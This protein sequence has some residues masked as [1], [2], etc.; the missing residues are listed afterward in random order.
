MRPLRIIEVNQEKSTATCTRPSSRIEAALS[1]KARGW[2]V[3]LIPTK[4]KAPITDDWANLDYT[5]ED[6]QQHFQY[7]G[8]IGIV[9]GDASGSLN[10]CDLDCVEALQLARVLL[11]ETF[12]FGRNETPKSHWIYRTNPSADHLELKH[13]VTQEK[14]LELRGNGGHQTVFPP[15]IHVSG[16]EIK[17]CNDRE[18]LTVD[19]VELVQTV[20]TLAAACL[21]LRHYPA[22]G[23]RDD[24]CCAIH[25]VLAR[26]DWEPDKA[27]ELVDAIATFAGDEEVGKRRKAKAARKNIDEGK[28]VMGWPKLKE[29]LGSAITAQISEWLK[30]KERKKSTQAAQLVDLAL[31]SATKFFLSQD[32]FSFARVPANDH[33]ENIAVK[34]EAFRQWLQ[35]TIYSTTGKPVGKNAI[36]EAVQIIDAK[37]RFENPHVEEVYVRTALVGDKVYLDLANDKWEVLEISADGYRVVTECPVQFRRLSGMKALPYPVAGGSLELLRKYLNVRGEDDWRLI[38]AYL[39]STLNKGPFWMLVIQGEPGSAKTTLS[40]IVKSITDPHELLVRS[41]PHSVEDVIIGARNSWILSYDNMSRIEPWLSDI[42][43]QVSTGA[44][45]GKREKYTDLDEILVRVQRPTIFNGVG[46]ILRSDFSNRALSVGLRKIAKPMSQKKLWREFESDHPLILGALLNVVASILKRLPEVETQELVLTRMA[47]AAEWV[48][49]AE[50]ALGWKEG[51]FLELCEKNQEDAMRDVLDSDP[52]AAHLV[53]YMHGRTEWD[54]G[55]WALLLAELKLANQDCP[56]ERYWPNSGKGLQC[57]VTAIM[58]PLR[59][60]GIEVETYRDPKTNGTRVKLT[61]LP[62]QE[63][64]PGIKKPEQPDI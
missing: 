62:H 32:G 7:P 4:S 37:T 48:I 5:E 27:D 45:L 1:Y 63:D 60:N 24:Y 22:A 53:S 30:G 61:K 16:Q 47:D 29:I 10:D 33:V 58:E 59:Q 41:A 28:K 64:L 39:L 35:Y 40:G 19:G 43:C 17:A 38:V 25:G 34:T 54:A 49:A 52:I 56:H 26:L 11:P 44:G 20:R 2:K 9:L 15:G 14:M 42:L 51:S 6:I 21:L 23:S 36:E 12:I 3:V 18:P 57:R 31:S 55:G 8:N 50:P 13:P 46:F